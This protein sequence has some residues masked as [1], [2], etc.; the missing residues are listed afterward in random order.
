MPVSA[1]PAIR[2][3]QVILE[4]LASDASRYLFRQ[5]IKQFGN[6]LADMIAQIGGVKPCPVEIAGKQD[7][8]EFMDHLNNRCLHQIP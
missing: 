7:F 8:P 6:R 5:H 3:L 1:F 2:A 4:T